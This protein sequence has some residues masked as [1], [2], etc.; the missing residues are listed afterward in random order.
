MIKNLVWQ[1]YSTV[2][3]TVLQK[4]V[5][6]F[7]GR[8]ILGHSFQQL[9]QWVTNPWTSPSLQNQTINL[10]GNT[11][12]PCLPGQEPTTFSTPS[13]SSIPQNHPLHTEAFVLVKSLFFWLEE[14]L[15]FISLNYVLCQFMSK[16]NSQPSACQEI[17]LTLWVIRATQSC[18]CLS[19]LWL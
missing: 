2:C 4:K 15:F 19:T 7:E 13:K 5:G 17:V 8:D 16:K 10:C 6:S 3:S 1:N 11:G 9:R 12:N 18:Q 14:G